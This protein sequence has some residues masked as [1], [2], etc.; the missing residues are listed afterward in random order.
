MKNRLKNAATGANF[1]IAAF[2]AVAALIA[3]A[4]L[5][6]KP[7]IGMADNGDYYR[8]IHNLGLYYLT[9]NFDDRHFGYFNRHF[10]YR[11]YPFE[12]TAVFVSS[13]SLLIRAALSLDL[14]LTG[15]D[16]F[17][18]RTMGWLYTAAFI[19]AF[20]LM[21]K[22]FGT[23]M[24]IPVLLA[25]G[26]LSVWIF[27]D[28]GYLAY[29]N[30][31]YGEPA[32]LILMFLCLGCG[33]RLLRERDPSIMAFAA[34][35]VFSA[36]FVAAKQ[37]NAPIGLL[38]A[39]VNVRMLFLRTDR[40]WR[41]VVGG[42]TIALLAISAFVYGAI[43]D[44][45]SHINQYHTVTRGILESSQ[46]PERDLE[47]LGL[48]RKFSVLAGTTYYDKYSMEHSESELMNERFYPNAGYGAVLKYYLLHPDRAIEKLELASKH[49]YTIRPLVI[50]NYEKSEGKGYGAQAGFFST[51]S[52]FKEAFFP[53][54]FRFL[55][56]FYALYY[57][58]L[59]KLYWDRYKSGNVRGMIRLELFAV[60]GLIGLLQLSVSFLGAGDADLA[61]HLFLFNVTFDFMFLAMVV[62]AISFLFSKYSMKV[63]RGSRDGNEKN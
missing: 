12:Q 45:I 53:K 16:I 57:G 13:L 23:N 51:W 60:V 30:S 17:D 34:F 27:A 21:L 58:F 54:G 62:Y 35:F 50:G 59:A 7:Y 40:R 33:F 11:K 32:S 19:G 24:K 43:K 42:L 48:D 22:Q 47:E 2:T 9:D 63:G 29:F 38:L 39:I 14:W 52:G 18:L 37:Q 15:D 20:Y 49:A 46:N 10:G 56:L 25:A 61:K 44:G 3:I 26:A 36:L 28:I 1:I 41:V 6:V 31:F 4:A 5:F 8:E 55:A